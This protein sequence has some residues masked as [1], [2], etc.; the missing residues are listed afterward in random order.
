MSEKKYHVF[1]GIFYYFENPEKISDR[2]LKKL[3]E[4]GWK[5]TNGWVKTSVENLQET[6]EEL[7][8]IAFS[9]QDTEKKQDD[10][11]MVI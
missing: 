8:K 3:L 11:K 6:F 1:K 7:L 9:E 4:A 5:Y 2:I 10:S